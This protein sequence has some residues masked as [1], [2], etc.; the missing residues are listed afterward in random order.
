MSYRLYE[1]CVLI[2]YLLGRALF[3]QRSVASLV[4]ASV[5][6]WWLCYIFVPKI[7]FREEQKEDFS[8]SDTTADSIRGSEEDGDFC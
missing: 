2:A 8:I 5:V 1:R 3:W 4:L 6:Y 7:A